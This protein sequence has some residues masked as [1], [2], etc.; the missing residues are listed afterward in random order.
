MLT[1]TLVIVKY[2]QINASDKSSTGST[3][4]DQNRSI[5]TLFVIQN[6]SMYSI[7]PLVVQNGLL[8]QYFLIILLYNW[9]FGGFNF[10]SKKKFDTF[11]NI[12]Y[13]G[14][15]FIMIA[16][17]I[18]DNFVYM[19]DKM[20]DLL[21]TFMFALSHCCFFKLWLWIHYKMWNI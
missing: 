1:L 12:L 10:Y 5:Q 9:L 4:D 17:I 20:R 7:W 16:S 8:V 21:H 18:M 13:L 15:Y 19:P 2:N 14:L 6:I 3:V 11:I